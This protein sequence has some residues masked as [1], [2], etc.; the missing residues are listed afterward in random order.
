MKKSIV[1]SAFLSLVISFGALA[2]E[3]KSEEKKRESGHY[4]ENKFRQMYDEMATP[5][6][7]RTASGAPGPAYYQQKADYK[8]NLELDDKN[9]KLYGSETITYYNNAPEALEYLWV[10][11]EQ[12][13]ERPDS[14]TPLVENQNMDKSITVT[15]FTKK[16]MD[17][18][19]EGGFNIEY[20]KDAKGNPMRYTIN[21][22]M[23][24]IDLPKPLKNGEKI[25]FSI[26][27]WYNIVN[28][29]EGAHNGRSGYEQFPDGN[30]LY[31]MA[32]FFPRMAVYND[33]EGWQNMQFWGRGEFALVFGDYDVNITV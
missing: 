17:K 2:Q 27:W 24:R 4:N 25:S 15:N 3:V 21:Q 13:I 28:Y 23:M 20:V 11:L 10:Q 8:M 9:K 1:L 22:T 33:V 7:F 32:Q 12:N 31:V 18:P 16:Y 19:F 26:K 5:N 6:M 30:R 29:M 14:K